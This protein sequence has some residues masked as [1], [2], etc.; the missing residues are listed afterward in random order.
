[1]L[2]LQNEKSCKR[3]F[4]SEGKVVITLS[5]T[6]FQ[7]NST[8]AVC[9]TQT[10]RQHK[11]TLAESHPFIIKQNCIAKLGPSV[12]LRG[13]VCDAVIKGQSSLQHSTR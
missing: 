4:K 2:L 13:S 8:S 11:I 1:M 6:A 3:G 5:Q 7:M 10:E 9:R 12:Q